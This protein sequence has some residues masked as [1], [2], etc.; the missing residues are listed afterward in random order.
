MGKHL[1]A[2][3][4]RPDMA[5]AAQ[6]YAQQGV[7]VLPLH[8][9]IPVRVSDY[10][11]SCSVSACSSPAK[12]PIGRL[13]PHGLD[14]ATTDPDVIA[15]WW[16]QAP[17]AN[18]GLVTGVIFDALDID[19]PAGMDAY[20]RLVE[21][22]GELD[23][24][25]IIQT[26][27]LDGGRQYYLQPAGQKTFTGGK[28]GIP[29][30]LDC[31]GAGG[32]VVA[33]PSQHI[34]GRRYTWITRWGETSGAGAA[35]GDV[36]A[37]LTQ[38]RL[39]GSE[40]APKAPVPAHAHGTTAYARRAL[41]AECATVAGTPQGGRNDQLNRSAFNLGQLVGAGQLDH[42]TTRQALIDAATTAGLPTTEAV[43]TA[44][45]GLTNGA[46]NP[47]DVPPLGM[48]P[49]GDSSTRNG[50]GRA[51]PT[52]AG[53]GGDV[54]QGD[55]PAGADEPAG[56]DQA[57]GVDAATADA[58][59][60][61]WEIRQQRIRR[62][63]RRA[64][65]QEEAAAGFP[66]PVHLPTLADDLNEPD[67]EPPYLIDQVMPAGANVLLTAQ[68]KTGKTTLINEAA[69]ALAENS[70]FLGRFE[71]TDHSGR[72]VI[73][74]FEMTPNQYRRW[75]RDLGCD[76]PE[77][78]TLVHLRGTRLPL[79]AEITQDWIV[80]TLE[81]MQAQTW[82]VDPFA[83]AFV[84]SGDENSNSDVGVALD[85][86][87]NIKE[88][89]GV[90]NLIVATHTGRATMDEG[91]ERARGATRLDDWA[92]VRWLLTKDEHGTRYLRAS[93]RDVEVD[94]E[95]LAFDAQT[96]RLT[97]GGG[98]RA[99]QRRSRIEKAVHDYIETNPGCGVRD[100]HAGVTGGWRAIDSARG[101]LIA[102]RQIYLIEEQGPGAAIKHYVRG[103]LDGFRQ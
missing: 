68:Y 28:N 1:K 24:L 46:A 2:I 15:E 91:A 62:L 11:C 8:Y 80:A 47:R 89:A 54:H 19:G 14:D 35:W 48:P 36:Y 41:E 29:T 22:T 63:A 40:P 34:T 60:L 45:S 4:D 71:I 58:Y 101:S 66:W 55:E 20:G 75:W 57:A 81:D 70:P 83:R 59:A 97:F 56:V 72:V 26:G 3:I 78:I 64:L 42:D 25:A 12:H 86:L 87:D 39:N 50:A 27:R 103:N 95:A 84:G 53:A 96:H 23:A 65:D 5:G 100:I 90:P 17:K 88:R 102:T 85:I 69:R 30:G 32:Y 74:N 77:R 6:W 37:H 44:N 51:V 76:K 82:I 52:S 21:A 33:V 94:E 10:A 13:V 98:D 61:A 9:P 16:R 49:A 31:R 67:T 7:P 92:D 73:F 93:G 43:R 38:H 18:I 99:W 79:I